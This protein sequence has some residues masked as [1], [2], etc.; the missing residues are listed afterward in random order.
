MEEEEQ[1]GR[2]LCT[3]QNKESGG[4]KDLYETSY[5]LLHTQ[6]ALLGE[7]ARGCWCIKRH[8]ILAHFLLQCSSK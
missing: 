3:M 8:L 2:Q 5:K 1:I 4:G 7:D 6:E